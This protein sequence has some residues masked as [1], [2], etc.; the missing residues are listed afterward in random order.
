MLCVGP[1]L[2]KKQIKAYQEK[3]GFSPALEDL[4]EFYGLFSNHIRLK[5][6]YLL[7]EEQRVCVCDFR[8]ILGVTSAAISQHLAKLKAHKVVQSV[9]QAQTVFYSLADH[10]FLELVIPESSQLGGEI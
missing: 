9:K 1:T 6:I 3:Y 7:K 10:P 2:T 4:S 8:D 5:I